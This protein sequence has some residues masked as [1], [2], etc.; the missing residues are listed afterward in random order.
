MFRRC[1]SQ[2]EQSV[3]FQAM[4]SNVNRLNTDTDRYAHLHRDDLFED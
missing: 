4:M 3:V 1:R 2:E